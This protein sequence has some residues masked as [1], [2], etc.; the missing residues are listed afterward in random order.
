M[1]LASHLSVCASKSRRYLPHRPQQGG[2][3]KRPPPPPPPCPRR[4]SRWRRECRAGAP[5]GIAPG[6]AA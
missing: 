5:G 4:G 6:G 2:D 3:V 1:G